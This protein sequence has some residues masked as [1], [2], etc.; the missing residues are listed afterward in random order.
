[1]RGNALYRFSNACVVSVAAVD[2]PI[3]VT[4]AEIDEQL[5]AVYE[6]LGLRSGMLENVAG[7]RERRWWP[8]DVT[9]EDAAVL[10][11]EKALIE[12]GIPRDRIGMLIDTSV[13]RAHLEP[14]ASVAVHHRLGMPTS[15]LNFDLSNAC[16]GFVNGMHLAAT[17]IDA[18]QIDY[19]LVVD[20]EGS[21]QPQ[22]STIARLLA[23]E[24]TVED[25]F[26]N[27]A[28]FT[29]GSGGTAMVLGRA[30]QHPEGHRVV[31]G[32][33]RAASQHHT[34]CVGDLDGMR[35]DTRALFEAG[36]E[37]SE[38]AWKEALQDFDWHDMDCY[39]IHQVS[40]VHTAA[41]C[42]RLGFDPARAP[43]TF[44]T[45]GNIGPASV[46]YTLATHAPELSKGDRV[47]AMGIGSGLNVSA[48]EIVW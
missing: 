3:T 41:I 29:L 43:L 36:L 31:G 8:E 30:D 15:C 38:D 42:E 4:S 19:A 37:L 1:M 47:L 6:R 13:S 12:S 9:F 34:L 5:A 27:F 16:L 24:P 14:S 48:L 21:R 46:P 7:V 2:A 22:Q 25:I 11:G 10:A 39:I 20:G 45:R 40:L 44:P 32:V 35:T 23:G 26:D 18:G 17:L 33:A 28:T